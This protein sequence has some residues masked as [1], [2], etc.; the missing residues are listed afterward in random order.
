MSGWQVG[1]VV[2]SFFNSTGH[3]VG[4]ACSR[5][6]GNLLRVHC[7]CLLRLPANH[8][9][10]L[11]LARGPRC[12][13]ETASDLPRVS[14]LIA[15]HN[16]ESVIEERIENALALDY[17]TD[18]LEIVVASDGSCD[19]T[20]ELVRAY[21][22]RGVRLIEFAER[23]GKSNVL[24][25]TIPNLTGDIILLSDA[26]T[27]YE[28]VAARRLARWFSDPRVGAVCGRLI[29]VDSATGTNVDSLYWHSKH[30]LR[31]AKVA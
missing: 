13:A 8:L 9:V 2:N 20:V 17:P 6:D 15:A 16:E 27:F 18:R 29:L 3:H 22:S 24:N 21:S 12:L 26:N 23:Q 10:P 11:A 7:L 19:R 1:H 31:N 30:F 14:L 28:P 25:C 5:D 4:R